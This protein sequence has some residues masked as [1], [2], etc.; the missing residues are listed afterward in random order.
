MP[1]AVAAVFFESGLRHL[2]DTLRPLSDSELERLMEEKVI[3]RGS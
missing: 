2:L 3:E 1:Y